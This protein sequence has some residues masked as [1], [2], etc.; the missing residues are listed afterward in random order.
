MK[1]PLKQI[2]S[3]I[4]EIEDLKIDGPERL[5]LPQLTIK[6]E[7]WYTNALR[8]VQNLIPERLEDFVSAYKN[9]RSGAIGYSTYTIQD[10]LLGIKVDRSSKADFNSALLF[11]RLTLRQAGILNSALQTKPISVNTSENPFQ[12]EFYSRALD[13]AQKLFGMGQLV[14]AGV[15]AGTVLENYLKWMCRRRNI[16]INEERLSTVEMNDSLYRFR[17]YKKTT[18]IRIKGL[19]PLAEACLKP[20]RKSPS[21][22]EIGALIAGV[23]KVVGTGL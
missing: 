16:R 14:P 19:I 23:K 9:N 8:V 5:D 13:K 6:Y 20:K 15:L 3:L 1:H 12:E 18:W 7:T 10:Y 17:T 22:E 21:K 4:K 11:E 2:K